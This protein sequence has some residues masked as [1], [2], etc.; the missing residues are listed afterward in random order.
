MGAENEATNLKSQGDEFW[1]KGEVTQ[2]IVAWSRAIASTDCSEDNLP[3][4]YSNRSA[5]HLRLGNHREAK[6][7]AEVCIAMR[8]TWAK[9]HMRLGKALM[10]NGNPDEAVY[11]FRKAS[12][13]DPD[14]REYSSAVND[15]KYHSK[16][17]TSSNN[18][19]NTAQP[20]NNENFNNNRNHQRN[21]NQNFN[22][23]QNNFNHPPWYQP[24]LGD[25]VLW[26]TRNQ[27]FIMQF[28]CI[29]IAVFV[30]LNSGVINMDAG[31]GG[32]VGTVIIVAGGVYAAHRSGMSPFQIMMMLNMLNRGGGRRRGRRMW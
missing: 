3:S 18:Q 20:N 26:Y 2:A 10:L 12:E 14:N 13:L 24:Y 5:A 19:S 32:E 22:H 27:R 4:L 6:A 29:M 21:Q 25:F 30:L 9:A 23:N 11:S 31:I 28:G 8:P 7:D 1:R 15:A 17:N 16:K